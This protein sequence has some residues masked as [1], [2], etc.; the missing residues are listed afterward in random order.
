MVKITWSAGRLRF[1]LR[2][3]PIALH[4]LKSDVLNY[5][6]TRKMNLGLS[7]LK[8]QIPSE[9]LQ[10]STHNSR[11]GFDILARLMSRFMKRL[12]TLRQS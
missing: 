11:V 5:F 7:S 9:F 3:N 6:S 8:D 10:N 2:L 12:F 1:F 4:F